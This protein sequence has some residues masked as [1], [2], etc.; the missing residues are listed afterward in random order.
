M[1]SEQ[2]GELSLEYIELRNVLRSDLQIRELLPN[3]V[4]ECR[5]LE[6]F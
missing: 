5:T 6:M 4:N 2:V 1:S 3:F